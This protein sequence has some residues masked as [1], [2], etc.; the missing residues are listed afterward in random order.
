VSCMTNYQAIIAASRYSRWDESKQRRE[1]WSETV[2]RMTGYWQDRC[3]LTDAE[4]KELYDATYNLEVMSSMRGL[5]TAGEAL[6]RDEAAIYNCAAIGLS[7]PQHSLPELMYLLMLGCGVGFSVEERFISKAPIVAEE[8]HDSDSVIVVQDSRI[9]WCKAFKTL[10]SMLYAGD[11]PKIDY[12]RIRDAGQPLKTFGG[13]ASGSGPLKEL[14]EFAERIFREN[15]G[16]KLHSEALHD[17][18][19]MVGCIVIAGSVR[20]SAEISLGDVGDARHRRLKTGEWYLQHGNRAMANNSA[21]FQG[22]PDFPTMMDEL[23]SLYLS[24]SGERGLFNREAAQKKAA[25]VGRDPNVDYICN[26]C[27]EILLDPDGGLCNLSEVVIRPKDTLKDLKRKVRLATIYGTMQSTLTDFRF[28]R[29]SWKRNAEKLRLLGVSLTGIMDHPVMSGQEGEEKLIKWLTEMREYAYEVNREWAKRLKINESAAICTIKPSG[30]VSQLASCASGQHPVYAPYYARTIRQDRK[31]PICEFLIDAGVPH[32]PCVMKPDSTMVFTFPQKSPEGSLTIDD[33]GT[34]Q[35]LELSKL[36]NQ[37]W[38]C[39]TCSLTAYYDG[40]GEDYFEVCQWIWD[41]FDYCIGVSFLP[42]DNG[43]YE[44]A[45]YT[46]ITKEEYDA[47]VAQ[48]PVIDWDKLSQFE[49]ED[50]TQGSHELACVGDKC[51]LK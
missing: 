10:L 5:W 14:F 25:K 47:M 26:P 36:Y 9:G 1:S 18:A 22:R 16:K 32:E 42:R 24:Y 45:P 40:S 50:R 11:V 51:E 6:D 13:R 4:T 39:H 2:K 49:L 37:H 34:I 20:R 21:V 3:G 30:T 12:S 15:A 29:A 38:A 7:D 28:L 27:A 17:I 48:E 8:F 35:Q 46:R 19:T 23:S 41:N 44:Q 43:T 33:V 31:D